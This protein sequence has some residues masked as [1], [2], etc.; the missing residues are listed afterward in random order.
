MSTQASAGPGRT[1]TRGADILGVVLV[2]G[3]SLVLQLAIYDRWISL[4]DEGF[5]LQTAAEVVRGKILYRDIIIPNPLPVVFYLLGAVFWLFEPTLQVARLL[6]V[7]LF[8]IMSICVYRLARL[9]VGPAGAAAAGLVFVA[10]RMWA[11]PHWHMVSYSTCAIFFATL[12]V[13]LLARS[14][15]TPSL[16]AA[17]GAG[18]L[19]GLAFFSKQDSG[20]AALA[21]LFVTLLC[22]APAQGRLRGVLALGAGATAV[23]VPILGFFAAHGALHD[24][25][26]QTVV[27]PIRGVQTFDYPGLP[28]LFPLF[29]Q[30]AGLRQYVGSY[31]PA[32]LFTLYWDAISLGSVYRTT[33][34][35][36]AGLKLVYYLPFAA[37]GVAALV[38]WRMRAHLD[39]PAR[40]GRALLLLLAMAFL[41]A[42]NKPRD[43]VHLMVLYYPT[44]LLVVVTAVDVLGMLPRWLRVAGR[45]VG[46]VVIVL[47]LTGSAWLAR[48]L[49]RNTPYAAGLPGGVVHVT[50]DEAVVLTELDRYVAETVPAGAPLPVFPYHP[51]VQFLLGRASGTSS[52]IIWPVRPYADLDERL[53]ADLEANE[54][55]TIVLSLSQYGHLN[56]FRENV[57]VLFAHL[58]DHYEMGRVFSSQTWGLVFTALRRRDDGGD[59]GGSVVYRFADH[60]GSAILRVQSPDG[61]R[62][63]VDASATRGEIVQ[64]TAWPLTPVIAVRPTPA[65]GWTRLEFDV[66]VPHGSY[67]RVG[68][69]MNPDHWLTFAPS[70][71]TFA[72]SIRTPEGREATLL[73]DRIDPQRVIGQRHW[74]T[75]TVDLSEYGRQN[76]RISFEVSTENHAGEIPDIAGWAEPRLLVP[77]RR[78][79]R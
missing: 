13:T 24:M 33:A 58:L 54:V 4:M 71:L 57:P 28:T 22:F 3:A 1:V 11:F 19:G 42:F 2:V 64:E 14:L 74:R 8:T 6:A 20:A 65:P 36:D 21:L 26:V 41:L 75:A 60:L 62:R 47:L 29:A 63:V 59:A 78:T 35:W 9:A 39:A 55:D 27:T 52:Y 23:A 72:L 37:L 30:D 76:A 77:V 66:S 43:W 7:A 46:G 56:R 34:W 31:F 16:A 51:L 15:P 10:Y 5:V 70:A 12:G 38:G 17:A 18:M 67:L 48:D 61:R 50:H 69:G 45:I 73:E 25:F 44:L 53:I 49:R 68:Y 32:I 40:A 79:Q